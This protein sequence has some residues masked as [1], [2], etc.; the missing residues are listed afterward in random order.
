MEPGATI[1]YTYFYQHKLYFVIG[2]NDVKHIMVRVLSSHH[3]LCIKNG[4]FVRY[5]SL[6]NLT[7]SEC[8]WQKISLDDVL[9]F[10]CSHSHEW[11]VL[12]L[13]TTGGDVYY[14]LCEI[15]LLG[16]Y[17]KFYPQRPSLYNGCLSRRSGYV[18]IN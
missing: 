7:I 8:K 5:Q 17:Q 12:Y 3:D 11:S 14:F 2:D 16:D 10:P 18:A 15:G 4:K 9:K 1:D 6:E 13:R